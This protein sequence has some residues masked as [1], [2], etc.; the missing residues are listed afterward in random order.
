M[1]RSHF[2]K[3]LNIAKQKNLM[4]KVVYAKQYARLVF[5]RNLHDRLL[6][7]VLNA[8]PDVRGYVL[9]NTLAQREARELLDSA[10]DYF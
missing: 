9:N 7:E 10:D 6:Q 2:E 5:D 4:I 1:G 3:A 8:D